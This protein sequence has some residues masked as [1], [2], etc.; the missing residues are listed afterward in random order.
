MFKRWK[1]LSD[2]LPEDIESFVN[3]YME[4]PSILREMEAFASKNKVPILLPISASFLSLL[5]TMIKPKDIL[6]IGTGIGYSTLSMYLSINGNCRITTIDSNANR[7]SIARQFF[8]KAN[9]KNINVIYAD[10]F[11]IIEDMMLKSQTFD[12]VLVDSAK[13]EYPFLNYKV[14]TLLNQN[15]LALFDNVL[16]RGMVVKKDV[17]KRYRRGI[18]LLRHFLTS[19]KDYPNFRSFIIPIGDGILVLT[20]T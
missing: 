11:D 9:A 14:Q 10:A 1:N 7:V 18:R 15:G 8:K 16:F 17:E 20:N 12:M 3:N 5:C 2:I 13:A 4:K 6:E 19:V